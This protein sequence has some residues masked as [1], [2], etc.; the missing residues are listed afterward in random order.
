[1]AT[2]ASHGGEV[3]SN[4]DEVSGDGRVVSLYD[5]QAEVKLQHGRLHNGNVVI[6]TAVGSG[7]LLNCSAQLRQVVG[8]VG[9]Q[10]LHDGWVDG[11]PLHHVIDGVARAPLLLLL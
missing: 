11:R 10:R 6:S 4:E 8:D 3:S 7:H 2:Q 5:P 1:V 9:G